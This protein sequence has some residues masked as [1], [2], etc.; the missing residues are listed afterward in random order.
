MGVLLTKKCSGRLTAVA[1]F[2][3]MRHGARY[4]SEPDPT[5]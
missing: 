1:D 4:S 2:V 3:V 5:D